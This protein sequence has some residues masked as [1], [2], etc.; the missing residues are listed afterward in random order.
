MK[1]QTLLTVD[2]RNR[3]SLGSLAMHKYYLAS[4][5]SDGTV[6]L[7]PAEVIPLAQAKLNQA[8][9]VMNKLDNFLEDS[10]TATGSEE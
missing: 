9:E 7:T 8:P 6:V 3:I 10:S 5:E 1:E 2:F 4:V